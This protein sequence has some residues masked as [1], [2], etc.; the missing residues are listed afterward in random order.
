MLALVSLTSD[1]GQRAPEPEH[2]PLRHRIQPDLTC[3]CGPP[4]PERCP[5]FSVTGLGDQAGMRAEVAMASGSLP[6][7]PLGLSG[8]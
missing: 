6:R 2:R 3:W 1:L 8:G 4:S 7:C 5:W